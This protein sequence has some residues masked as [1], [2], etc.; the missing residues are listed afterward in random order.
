VS[1]VERIEEEREEE[2]ERGAKRTFGGA[3]RR[4]AAPLPA[5]GLSNIIRSLSSVSLSTINDRVKRTKEKVQ[6]KER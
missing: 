4:P 3:R 5:F 6:K 1:A 2:K